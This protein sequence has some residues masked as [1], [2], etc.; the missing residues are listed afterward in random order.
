MELGCAAEAVVRSTCVTTERVRDAYTARA[1]E[2]IDLIG[3]IDA[4]SGLDRDRVLAWALGIDGPVIDVGCG[5][6]QWTAFLAGHGVA[7]EGID[8]VTAFL[9]EARRRH[10]DV[11]FRL[12]RAEQLDVDDASLGGILAWYSLIHMAPSDIDGVLVEFARSLRPEGSLA[13]GFFEGP[14]LEPFDHAVT[15]AHFWPIDELSAR[16]DH[17]GFAVEEVHVRTDLG[18]RRQGLILA[19]RSA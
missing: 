9:E 11:Q 16:I 6:G 18:A 13:V 5:P 10:P 2:Y 4:S 14:R 1:A 12:G 3:S 7:I 19:R 8:P 15:T 17:A